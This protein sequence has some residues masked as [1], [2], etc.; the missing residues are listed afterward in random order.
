M[1]RWALVCLAMVGATWV[2]VQRDS[3]GSVAGGV[4]DVHAAVQR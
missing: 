1:I 4:A 3:P 2:I